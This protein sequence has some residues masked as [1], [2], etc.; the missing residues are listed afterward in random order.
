ME[1]V[2]NF[3]SVVKDNFFFVDKQNDPEEKNVKYTRNLKTSASFENT[4]EEHE[5]L[6]A[7][8]PSTG[9]QTAHSHSRHTQQQQQRALSSETA[10]QKSFRK[11]TKI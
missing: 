11:E 2:N 6:L 9:T 10:K 4:S 8:H 7:I 1:E 5:G 3:L